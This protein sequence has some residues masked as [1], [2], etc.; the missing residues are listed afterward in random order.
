LSFSASTYGAVLSLIK[1]TLKGAGAIQGLPGKSAYQ[2]WLA[3]GNTGTEADFLASL[4]ANVRS[5][6]NADIE[7][8]INGLEASQQG[9]GPLIQSTPGLSAYQI[10]L[11]QGNTGTEA[12]FLASL[13]ANARSISNAEIQTII[14]NL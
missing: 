7:A 8:I 5:I 9:T 11:A 4:K 13:K 2:I 3:Q 1:A 6:S 14:N 10:W 12:D